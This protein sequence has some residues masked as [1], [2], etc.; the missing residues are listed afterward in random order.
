LR[1]PGVNFITILCANF[2]YKNALRSFSLVTFWLVIFWR[3]NF[4]AI[5]VHKMLMKLTPVVNFINILQAAFTL[6]SF[7][8][9]NTKPAVN[10]EKLQKTQT[11]RP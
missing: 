6:I 1:P 2:S 11:L 5:G 3:K 4:G 9:K 8:I 7:V 10:I